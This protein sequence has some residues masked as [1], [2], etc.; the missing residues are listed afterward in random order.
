YASAGE[1]A[2]DLRGWLEGRPVKAKPPSA[3]QRLGWWARRHR[4][5]VAAAAVCLLVLFAALGG[6][7]G[8]V[9]RDAAA[10]RDAA[11]READAAAAEGE[12]YAGQG[13]WV[14]A[15]AAARR[16]EAALQS[17]GG[18]GPSARRVRALLAD[19]EM[20]QRLERVRLG[21]SDIR[22]AR[23]IAAATDAAY[24]IAFLEY[25]ANVEN[26]PRAE[27]ARRLGSRPVRAALAAALDDWAMARRK[28]RDGDEAGWRQLLE[29]ARDI[30]PDPW[31]DRLRAA[32]AAMDRDALEELARSTEAGQ[33]PPA[34]LVPLGRALAEVGATE[35]AVELLRAAQR[36]HHGDFWV[37]HTLGSHLPTGSDEAVRFLSAAAAARPQSPGALLSLGLALKERGDLDEAIAVYQQAI[38]LAPDYAAAHNNLGVA[39]LDKGD[40]AGAIAEYCEAI[41]IEPG[42]AHPHY[43]LGIAL[44]MRG[45][46]DGAIAAYREAIRIETGYAEAHVNLGLLLADRGD[47]DGAVREYRAAIRA[48]PDFG[49]AH[50]NLG[51]TLAARGD[52]AAAAA[53]F[54]EAARARPAFAVAHYNLAIT[55]A[56]LGDLK[57]A[58]ASCREAIR[59]RPDH[60]EAHCNLGSFLQRQGR[61]A[62]SLESYRRGHALGSGR[63]GWPF[64]SGDWVRQ[65]ELL[66][67]L[68]PRLG[69]FRSGAAVPADGSEALAVARL[70]QLKGFY[71][72]AARFYAAAFTA[73]PALTED[74]TKQRRYAAACAAVRAATGAGGG[75]PPGP[76]R[77]RLRAQALEWLRGEI[78]TWQ[79][80]SRTPGGRRDLLRAVTP[81]P[82]D[83]DLA[84]VRDEAALAELP[85]PERAAWLLLWRRVDELLE[86]ARTAPAAG[87]GVP[88]A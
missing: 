85:D 31:R 84:P 55:L 19:L 37:N 40:I 11:H 77:E 42:Y 67:A 48:R 32:L 69:E 81:W 78:D 62:E 88:T 6:S 66:A 63:P 23:R 86:N 53:A 74:P 87:K 16:A 80:W 26:L 65:A 58:E 61:F 79:N 18:D 64:P 83:P 47:L 14:G 52:L 39:R 51:S 72:D 45:D 73:D 4:P 82:R 59:L 57:G 50:N 49:V 12:A 22:E 70:C 33:L 27:A 7:A 30:D 2:E 20:G 46:I 38:R 10:K 41:R 17:A 35:R 25:G 75:P 44:S 24:R 28:A 21:Q 5:A 68:E 36:R 43:N 1:L 9:A 8:W 29:L 34:T 15:W 60:A 76:E 71:A 54:R 3:A 56:D 13:D